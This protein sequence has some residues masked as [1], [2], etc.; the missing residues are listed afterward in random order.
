MSASVTVTPMYEDDEYD[1]EDFVSK[2][3]IKREMQALQDLGQELYKLSPKD[4]A[5]IPLP[6]KLAE[7]IALA[8]RITNRSGLRRQMQYIGKVMRTIDAEPIQAALDKLRQS[9]KQAAAEFHQIERWR[10]RLI[11]EGNDAL[12]EFLTQYSLA[13]RQ[14]LRQLMINAQKEAKQNKPPKYSRQLF[15]YLRELLEE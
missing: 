15:R 8:H 3:Q 1:D 11:A 12:S 7:S 13:D 9:K 4:L 14:H 10:D 2:S 6:E 5:K